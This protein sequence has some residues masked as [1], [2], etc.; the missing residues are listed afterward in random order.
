MALPDTCGNLWLSSNT[1]SW[2]KQATFFA[3]SYKTINANRRKR[4]KTSVYFSA[5]MLASQKQNQALPKA[6]IQPSA[7]QSQ[8]FRLTTVKMVQLVF[9]AQPTESICSM[10][11]RNWAEIEFYGTTIIFY[12]VMVHPRCLQ[13]QRRLIFC[14]VK[15]EVSF[16]NRTFEFELLTKVWSDFNV[17]YWCSSFWEIKHHKPQKNTKQCRFLIFY[18]LKL[19][20]TAWMNN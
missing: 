13:A 5:L 16:V 18:N 10:I 1:S 19:F 17:S 9:D 3:S 20:Q 15:F 8:A 7:S 14:R 6:L 12:H 11:Q 4:C 2:F